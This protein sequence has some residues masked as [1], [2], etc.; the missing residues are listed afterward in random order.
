MMSTQIRFD[1]DGLSRAIESGNA[2]YQLALYANDA[3]VQIIDSND[4]GCCPQVLH[5]KDA[6]GTWINDMLA[7]C[8]RPTV[9]HPVLACDHLAL[10]EELH[11]PDG[12]NLLYECTAEVHG[13]QII[14]ET[15]TLKG[16][17][18]AEA[19]ASDHSAAANEPTG[20][21]SPQRT[22]LEL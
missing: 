20:G 17:W 22:Q 11:T 7:Q 1:L 21:P 8:V 9:T 18:R 15:V 10:V 2:G 16:K 14:K 6:I 5:G 13:G 12:T 3:E 19:A 4:P